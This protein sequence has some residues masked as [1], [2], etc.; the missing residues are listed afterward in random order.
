M[1]CI[2]KTIIGLQKVN[3]IVYLKNK[4]F[5]PPP[6][7]PL[8]WIISCGCSFFTFFILKI[9]LWHSL[10]ILTKLGA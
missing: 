4:D 1:F 3:I 9:N 10:A 6:D 7:L 5:L 2:G 8:V